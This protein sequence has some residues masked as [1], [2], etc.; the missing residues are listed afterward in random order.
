MSLDQ[1]LGSVLVLTVLLAFAHMSCAQSLRVVT[2][3][4]QDGTLPKGIRIF[5]ENNYTPDRCS[6]LA[7]LLSQN[8]SR[9]PVLTDVKQWSFV[10]VSTD[11]WKPLVRSLKGDPDSP[12]FTVLEN[13]TTVVESV[14]LDPTAWRSTELFKKFNAQGHDLLDLSLAHEM[15]HVVCNDPNEYRAGENGRKLRNQKPVVCLGP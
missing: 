9:F 11:D 10:I 1:K 3:R 12:A 14:L 2:A 8:L 5:C 15:G 4:V 13:R 6:S 7:V